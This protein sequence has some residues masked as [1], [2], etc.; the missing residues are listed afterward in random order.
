M[1]WLIIEKQTICT[2]KTGTL[3]QNHMAV[4][5]LNAIIYRIWLTGYRYRRYSM[6]TKNSLLIPY[7]I[8]AISRSANPELFAVKVF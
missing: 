3:T 6:K 8:P 4:R 7:P 1:L 2:D 5:A